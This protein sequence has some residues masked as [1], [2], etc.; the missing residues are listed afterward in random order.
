MA[1][2]ER[3]QFSRIE[4]D[5]AMKALYPL[6][7]EE[8]PAMLMELDGKISSGLKPELKHRG[9]LMLFL[10]E[11]NKDSDVNSLWGGVS[12]LKT[13][14]VLHDEGNKVW[15]LDFTTI[16][17]LKV[18]AQRK[19]EEAAKKREE[20]L[21]AIREKDRQEIEAA[22]KQAREAADKKKASKAQREERLKQLGKLPF[23]K[24][25]EKPV[26]N[27]RHSTPQQRHS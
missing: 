26:K 15:R 4:Y 9:M 16:V 11:H 13:I 7:V 27:G 23:K 2:I 18:L 1:F 17:P 24:R 25:T 20:E 14:R 22:K 5:S 12:N 19:A 3:T 10:E 6:N 8:V 21:A